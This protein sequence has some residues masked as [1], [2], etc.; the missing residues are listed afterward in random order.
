MCTPTK[1]TIYDKRGRV[2][3]VGVNSLTKSHPF[4]KR[5]AESVGRPQAIF[6]HAEVQAILKLRKPEEAHTIRVERYHAITGE[7]LLA[8]PCAI[9]ERAISI[10]G[11]PRVLYTETEIIF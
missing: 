7:P 11:I 4:Q 9:C 10:V 3:S 1:A 8:K 2:L 5:L 6:L